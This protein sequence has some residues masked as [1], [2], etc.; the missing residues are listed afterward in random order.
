MY[1]AGS[2]SNIPYAFLYRQ[3]GTGWNLSKTYQPDIKTVRYK[4]RRTGN[5]Q[6]TVIALQPVLAKDHRTTFLH[7]KVVDRIRIDQ[8]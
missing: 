5:E 7:E 4:M 3:A 2:G 8:R 1:D 6:I